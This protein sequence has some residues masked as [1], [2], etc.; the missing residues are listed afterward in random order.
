LTFTK[1][2]NSSLA[3]GRTKFGLGAGR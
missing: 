1:A 3:Y 2:K